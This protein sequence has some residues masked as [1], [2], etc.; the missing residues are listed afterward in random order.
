[1]NQKMLF[2]LPREFFLRQLLI[3]LCWEVFIALLIINYGGDSISG[4]HSILIVLA[5]IFL[6]LYPHSRYA[7]Q[8]IIDFF[9]GT[10]R[11]NYPSV[12]ELFHRKM[13]KALVSMVLMPILGPANLVV[14][15]IL[16]FRS[17]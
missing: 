12:P 3:F 8:K 6:I 16:K 1:M 5:V 17:R 11:L 13:E 4:Q 2:L 10:D 14:L 7:T 9:I 15:S